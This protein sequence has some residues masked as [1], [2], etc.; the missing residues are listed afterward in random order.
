MPTEYTNNKKRDVKS[1]IA[2]LMLITRFNTYETISRIKGIQK[3]INICV[4]I[5]LEVYVDCGGIPPALFSGSFLI[6]NDF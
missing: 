3:Y 2:N 1:C 4:W 5:A 6:S